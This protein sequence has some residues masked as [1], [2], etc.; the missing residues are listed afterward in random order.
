MYK[1]ELA[2][3]PLPREQTLA[4]LGVSHVTVIHARTKILTAEEAEKELMEV[5]LRTVDKRASEVL[6]KIKPTDT[7]ETLMNNYSKQ[8]GIERAN[9]KFFFAGEQLESGV[10]AEDLEL[11]D[12]DIFDVKVLT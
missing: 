8:T 1:E 10:T 12:G 3:E 2:V 5:K 11:E 9:I 4:E 7:M 6:M